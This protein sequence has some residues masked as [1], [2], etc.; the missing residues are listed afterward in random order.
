MM[1]AAS[2]MRALIQNPRRRGTQIAQQL[3]GYLHVRA[4]RSVQQPAGRHG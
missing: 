2:A 3:S 4:T 1:T